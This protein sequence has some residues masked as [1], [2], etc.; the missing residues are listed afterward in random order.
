M[1][2]EVLGKDESEDELDDVCQAEHAPKLENSGDLL[3]VLTGQ[4]LEGEEDW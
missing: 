3:V 1:R 4:V 2:G